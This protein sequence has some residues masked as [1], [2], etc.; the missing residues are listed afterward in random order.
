MTSNEVMRDADLAIQN[1]RLLQKTLDDEGV[2]KMIKA[3]LT[4]NTHKISGAISD[5]VIESISDSDELEHLTVPEVNALAN[6]I[7]HAI[8]CELEKLTNIE[9][10]AS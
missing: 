8:S 5:R 1:A 2:K 10:V 4:L 3:T 9:L 7:D 6:I